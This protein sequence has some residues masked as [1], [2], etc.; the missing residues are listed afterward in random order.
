VID[1]ASQAILSDVFR[2]TS[3]SLLQ[4]VRDSFPWTTPGKDEGLTRLHELAREE[5]AA[6]ARLGRFF[7]RHHLPLPYP[8]SYPSS[9]TTI[10]FI[11]LGHLQKLLVDY[12]RQEIAYLAHALSLVR[13][14]EVR[15]ELQGLS[16][17]KQRHLTALQKLDQPLAATLEPV[18]HH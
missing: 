8:G 7:A 10:N 2:R 3:R 12:Q 14:A 13:D 18:A 15:A 9:F 17:L 1:P 16:D 5:E 11:G 4:Y 6:L